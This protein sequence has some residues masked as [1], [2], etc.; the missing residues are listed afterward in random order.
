METLPETFVEELIAPV[1]KVKTKFGARMEVAVDWH[2]QLN[3]S[4][5]IRFAKILG[6]DSAM[7]AA[8]SRPKSANMQ[9]NSLGGQGQ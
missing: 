6:V 7:A 1:R 9:S 2:N 3:L 8:K 4:S 5:A